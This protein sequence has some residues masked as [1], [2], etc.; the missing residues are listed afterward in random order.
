M[1]VDPTVAA[2]HPDMG[3]HRPPKYVSLYNALC[4]TFPHKILSTALFG[5][6]RTLAFCKHLTAYLAFKERAYLGILG[7]FV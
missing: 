1:A 5:F 7:N 2:L 3:T 6:P 4:P